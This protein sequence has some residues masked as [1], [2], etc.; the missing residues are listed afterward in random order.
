MEL[1][2]PMEAKAV[3]W[4]HRQSYGTTGSPMEAKA[5]LWKLRQS[6]GS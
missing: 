6:Y 3:L 4:N 2:S 5:V 1:S